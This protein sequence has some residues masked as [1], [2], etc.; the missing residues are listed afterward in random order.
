V[1]LSLA[2]EPGFW[3]DLGSP[4]IE[5][6][7]AAMAPAG[8]R[9]ADEDF[10]DAITAAFGK[11]IDAKSPFTAGHSERVAELTQALGGHFDMLPAR[12][13]ELRRAA[14]LHDVG[15]LGVSSAILEKPGALGDEEWKT[16]REHAS[17]TRAILARIGPLAEL[18]DVA[19]AHHERLDGGGYPLGLREQTISRQTR[20]ITLCD[21]YDALTADR[22]YRAAMPHEKAMAIIE[23]E[24]G[25]AVDGACFAALREVLR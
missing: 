8:E 19:A 6:R 10:L 9:E 21:F 2:D 12:L 22:P 16:M 7:V 1:F 15:K 3:R 24:V 23:S 18:A 20:I 17:H 14:A 25:K 11:V 4:L 13:R 5:A